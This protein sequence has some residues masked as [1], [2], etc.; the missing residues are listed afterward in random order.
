LIVFISDNG[1]AAEDFYRHEKFG[2][3]I[4]EHFTEDYESMGKPHSFV[5]YGPQWAEAG[6]SP[7]KYFKAYTTQGGVSAPMI[8]AGPGIEPGERVVHAFTTLMDLAPTFYETA[9]IAYPVRFQHKDVYPLKGRSLWPLL[10]GKSDAIHADDYVFALE[11]RGHVLIRQGNWKLVNTTLPL[12]PDNF[13]LHD[14]SVDLAEQRDLKTAEPEK[15]REMLG[16]WEALKR[17][18]RLQIPTP[19]AAH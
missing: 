7:F 18:T 19:E 15:F 4:R 3:F 17:E 9:G 13:E 12:N 1:A 11:H 2:P 5:S 8:V 10:A 14:L 16:E 6:A